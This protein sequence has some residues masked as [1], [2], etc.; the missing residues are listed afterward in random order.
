MR[1]LR[2]LVVLLLGM[3]AGALLP[4]APA[5]A[6]D[7]HG[8]PKALGTSR[9]LA[10]EPGERSRF[11]VMQYPNSLPLRDKEVVLTFDD[12][13]LPP[14]SDQI[15]D[16]LAAQCVKVTYFLVG[17]MAHEFP[18]TVRRIYT[19]GHTIG[20]H[21]ED[22][23]FRF[24]RLPVEKLRHEID[25]GIAAVGAAL[26]DPKEV[27][28]FFRIP[29]LGRTEIIEREL[30]ARSLA[31]FSSDT[32]ADDWFHRIKASEIV[33]RAMNRLEALGK[34]ILLLHDIHPATVAALPELLKELKERG[35]HVVH[36]VPAPAARIEIAAATPLTTAST[37]PWTHDRSDPIWPEIIVAETKDRAVLPAPD[38]SSFDVGYE[39]GR[40]VILAA[41]SDEAG[42]PA[43]AMGTQ[44]PDESAF[45]LPSLEVELPA[46]RVRDL[47]ASAEELPTASTP[48]QPRSTLA[49]TRHGRERERV[50]AKPNRHLQKS[51]V[52]VARHMRSPIQKPATSARKPLPRTDHAYRMD[53]SRRPVTCCS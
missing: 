29:G 26:G 5:R 3:A 10:L 18:A 37:I 8:D 49:V 13:P 43:A 53:R 9:V 11:G 38:T 12:G 51:A 17:A 28:P 19:A 22:H 50:L 48:P 24:E 46:P 1:H 14:Y 47:A 31:V 52:A 7:C 40:R 33:R 34:G 21:S 42:I 20:T 35:F 15:L 30:T 4:V 39:P 23:P 45:T 27:A 6:Q 16:I 32:V 44:W 36:V 41:G 2:G 25:D